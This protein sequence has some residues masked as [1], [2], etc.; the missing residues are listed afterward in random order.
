MD[1]M[2][3]F[4]HITIMKHTNILLSGFHENQQQLRDQLIVWGCIRIKSF[5][6]LLRDVTFTFFY[7]ERHEKLV[8]WHSIKGF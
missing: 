4:S 1:P 3:V 7:R 5:Y 2:S 8:T 6:N